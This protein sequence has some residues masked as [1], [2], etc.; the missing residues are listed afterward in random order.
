MAFHQSTVDLPGVW[1]VAREI[2]CSVLFS[3]NKTG[4]LS[5]NH[6]RKRFSA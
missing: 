5:R 4:S 6:R 3:D 2:V 1:S